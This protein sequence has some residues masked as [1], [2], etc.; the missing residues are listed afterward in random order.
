M[1]QIIIYNIL[2]NLFS[3]YTYLLTGVNNYLYPVDENVVEYVE[4]EL[5]EIPTFVCEEFKELAI[6][7]ACNHQLQAPPT[8]FDEALELYYTLIYVIDET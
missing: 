1:W 3:Y 4:D 6:T 7:I 5:C 2:F 8:T